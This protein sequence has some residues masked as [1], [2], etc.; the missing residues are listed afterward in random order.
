MAHPARGPAVPRTAVSLHKHS[1]GHGR[2][3]TP[4]S[5]LPAHAPQ[6][7]RGPRRAR[8]VTAH[9]SLC[10]AGLPAAGARVCGGQQRLAHKL[11][12]GTPVCAAARGPV[13]AAADT[14]PRLD[15]PR[16]R[17]GL[18]GTVLAPRRR[19]NALEQMLRLAPTVRPPGGAQGRH[20]RRCALPVPLLPLTPH[21]PLRGGFAA[22]CAPGGRSIGLLLAGLCAAAPAGQSARETP[23]CLPP[24]GGTCA[25]HDPGSADAA[26]PVAAALFF[27]LPRQ[28]NV[29]RRSLLRQGQASRCSVLRSLD[30]RSL[31]I[32]S[33]A[34]GGRTTQMPQQP[35][36]SRPGS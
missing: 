19:G 15:S 10:P 3:S 25:L 34:Q 4:G 1:T 2:P 9:P 7:R 13:C 5:G 16:A 24:P 27:L 12:Q 26:L 23:G 17:A 29:M 22:R 36:A 32:G 21:P 8:P 28:R 20:R 35:A 30:T 14:A 6:R 33:A 11:S 31:R 18:P